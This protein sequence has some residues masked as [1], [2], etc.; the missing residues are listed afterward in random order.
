MLFEQGDDNSAG[1][2]PAVKC[3]VL[4]WP[5]MTLKALK[6]QETSEEKLLLV[7]VNA[8]LQLSKRKT[9]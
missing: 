4:D 8:L 2:K 5:D 1:F 9:R 3:E 6:D 7:K